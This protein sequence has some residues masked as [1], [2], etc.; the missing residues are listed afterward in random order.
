M[1]NNKDII[2]KEQVA[3]IRWRMG[4][5]RETHKYIIETPRAGHILLRCIEN[6]TARLTTG[7]TEMID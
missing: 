5:T 3:L 2:R 6:N 7:L 1:L 4:H